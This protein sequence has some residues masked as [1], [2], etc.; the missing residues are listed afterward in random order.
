MSLEQA[1]IQLD[2]KHLTMLREFFTQYTLVFE[3]YFKL[4]KEKN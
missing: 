3:E 1:R 2:L 4:Y